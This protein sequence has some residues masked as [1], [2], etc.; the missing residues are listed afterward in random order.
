VVSNGVI[1]AIALIFLPIMSAIIYYFIAK[2]RNA[3][4][5]FWVAMGLV[6][7][8]FAIPFVFFAK[9]LKKTP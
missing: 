3:K 5:S 1:M 2:Q 9:S 8:I 7:A 4:T 6:F